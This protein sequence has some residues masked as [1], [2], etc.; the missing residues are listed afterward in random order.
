MHAK[1]RTEVLWF[2]LPVLLI[3]T[4]I[5]W[6]VRLNEAEFL[7]KT[8]PFDVPHYILSFESSHT[9]DYYV[10]CKLPSNRPFNIL[11]KFIDNNLI[12]FLHFFFFQFDCIQKWGSWFFICYPFVHASFSSDDFQPPFST[13]H[14]RLR[15][16]PLTSLFHIQWT[17]LCFWSFMYIWNSHSQTS[18]A[19]LAA[20]E[21]RIVLARP[22]SSKSACKPVNS[23]H[24]FSFFFLFTYF[25]LRLKIN[26]WLK[27]NDWYL[28]FFID[29]YV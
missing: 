18:R 15:D 2:N 9:L 3:V 16:I 26:N 1:G 17:P 10:F 21:P 23:S 28:K 14:S 24:F 27:L 12:K 22:R 25:F 11:L 19:D 8:P 13:L 6:W 5:A 20:S 29:S 4:F 7:H